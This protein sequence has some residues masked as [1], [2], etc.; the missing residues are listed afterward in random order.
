MDDVILSSADAPLVPLPAPEGNIDR[1]YKGDDTDKGE[2]A[3]EDKAEPT[4]AEDRE[5]C[6]RARER[7]EYETGL[8][9]DN[10]RNHV[11]DL[12]FAW[13]KGAQWN[14]QQRR[15]RETAKPPRPWL[16]FN[17]TGQFVKQVVNDQRQNQP[18]IKIRPKGKGAT[19]EVAD[20]FSGHIRD[21]E[22]ASSA[23]A[24]YDSTLEQGVTG[25]RGYFRITT[26]YEA[27][28]SFNQVARIRPIPDAMQV[29]M[30]SSSVEPDKSDIKYCF[31]TEY[32]DK[33][34]FD[35]E[36][37]DAA[38]SLSWDTNADDEYACYYAN[39][40]VCVADYFEIQGEQVELCV[41]SDKS[42]MWRDDYERKV[43]AMAPPLPD[44]VTGLIDPAAMPPQIMRSELRTRN[45]VAWYKLSAC[46]LPLA[47]YEWMGKF[48]PVLMCPG[49]EITISGRKIYQGII[50]RLR[51]A[52]M[53]YN[54]WFTLA[55]ERIALAPKS[56]Y[57]MLAGQAENHP[58]WR[59]ANTDNAAFLEYEPVKVGNEWFVQP[60][61]RTEAIQIDAGLVTMLQ[62]CAQ[63]LREITGMKDAVLGQGRPEQP[64]GAI[65]AEQKK[66]D[67]A[68]FHYGDNLA[69]AIKHAGR[70]LV[71]LIPKI[72][73]VQRELAMRNEDGTS[74]T[75]Q[76]NVPMPDGTK[77]NDLSVGDF[78]VIV[79]VG[80]SFASRR[81]EA[82]KE[83]SEFMQVVGPAAAM[84]VG[85]IMA[86]QV[87]WPG[88]TGEKVAAMLGSML[89]PAQQQILNGGDG[90]DPQVASLQAAMQAQ[91]QQFTQ[92]AQQMQG[93]VAQLT[94]DNAELKLKVQNK[95]MEFAT[96][97]TDQA[98]R[99]EDMS[100]GRAI[101]AEN[102]AQQEFVA[103]LDTIPKM[104]D[105]MVKLMTMGVDPN[106]IQ[107][108]IAS[109]TQAV[110]GA[111]SQVRSGP[112][113]GQ[114]MQLLV[115]SEQ[116][117]NQ[118]VQS[119]LEQALPAGVPQPNAP[120][121]PQTPPGMAESP[122]PGQG[123]PMPP[124]MPQ[125]P[126]DGGQQP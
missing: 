59:N 45:K 57:V 120:Q 49:D 58:E 28:D 62:I 32:I 6:I 100:Q 64:L 80:P 104:L 5:V 25:G 114:S 55:T 29:I 94:A 79:D 65:L 39:G 77:L 47:R 102:N 97:L 31:I 99:R 81:V 9:A 113:F 34:T 126:N 118:R 60:P 84:P 48:I 14:E 17:Q 26:E 30:D 22:Y 86:Q 4:D 44:M 98:T 119:I 95:T 89:P 19:Q 18:A 76:V 109:A 35:A 73:D 124:P 121:A 78:E 83:M 1:A 61:N 88:D 10:R 105:N 123:G 54:Y 37:P 46:D 24:I 68:T 38:S 12:K 96:K 52:Q 106:S 21:I 69:R 111:S 40:K 53:M 92:F 50:R 87:D 82:A 108:L 93:H 71:D 101:A 74:S 43:M 63:N 70:I 125:N 3:A 8:D 107:G 7:F 115:G 42:V 33:D 13:E 27:E 112:D 23:P 75:T 66:G 51:D 90:Q 117:A 110:M 67:V 15:Q 41:L 2:S 122:Q 91:Q 56:P 116:E 11:E 16:E 20:I 103:K 72:T 85:A 36:W